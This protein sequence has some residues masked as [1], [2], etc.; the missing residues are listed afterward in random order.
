MYKFET[1]SRCRA[2]AKL[3]P[4]LC[5]DEVFNE[6][7]LR[8]VEK[9]GQKKIKDPVAL[10]FMVSKSSARFLRKKD[11]IH[12]LESVMEFWESE[13]S[14]YQTALDNYLQKNDDTYSQV[15]EMYL[16]CPNISK[17]SRDTQ[18]KKYHLKQILDNA[19]TRVGFEYLKLKT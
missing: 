7:F 14:P 3:Y 13:M 12:K 2:I 8:V 18:I 19:L 1:C 6:T 17:I 5:P 11:D 10:F 15:I 9:Y 4:D 16:L